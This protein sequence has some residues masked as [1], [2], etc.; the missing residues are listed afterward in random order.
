M[1]VLQFQPMKIYD[2]ENKY[3]HKLSNN[4]NQL[5]YNMQRGKEK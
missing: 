4:P 3:D 1:N 5:R 2:I